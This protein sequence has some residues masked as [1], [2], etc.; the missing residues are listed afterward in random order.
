MLFNK[1]LLQL[2]RMDPDRNRSRHADEVFK[3]RDE[4]GSRL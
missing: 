3:A 4:A 2:Y 1:R